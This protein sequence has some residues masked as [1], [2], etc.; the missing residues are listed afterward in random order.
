MADSAVLREAMAAAITMATHVSLHTGDPA[1]TGAS[2]VSG[3][4]YARVAITSWAP[5]AVDGVYVAT[6]AGSFTVP[7][8]TEIAWA[9]LWNGAVY[10]DK[11]PAT[12][13]TIA[14]DTV[15]ILSLTFVVPSAA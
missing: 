2:E 14:A 4:G 5:G 9:G 10:L 6:L 11:A 13:S 1:G 15:S 8:N 7:A 12:A 3:G